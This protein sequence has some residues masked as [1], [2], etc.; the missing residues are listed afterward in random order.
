MAVAA[1]VLPVVQPAA[2]VPGPPQGSWTYADYARL[3]DDGR[4]YEIIDVVLYVAP[5]P[6]TS[7]QDAARWFVYD[8]TQHVHLTGRGLVFSAPFDVELTAR[9]VVQPDV[10]VV[11]AEHASIITPSRIIGAPDLVIEIISP[12]TAGYD[13]RQKQDVYAR[14]GVRE[15]WI[16]DPGTRT[17]ET[18]VLEAGTYRSLGAF[19]GQATLLSQIVPDLPVRVEQFFVE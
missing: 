7:H 2:G 16:A 8:L 18:L 10:L 17:I 12:S 6:N 15:C 3:P 19:Q 14:A 9:D 5:S 1:D 13:R 11:L 4:R